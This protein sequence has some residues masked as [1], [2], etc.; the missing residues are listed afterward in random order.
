[1][2]KLLCFLQENIEIALSALGILGT[3]LGTWLGWILNTNTQKLLTKPFVTVGVGISTYGHHEI[4]ENLY[5]KEQTQIGARNIQ[6]I[7]ESNA[8]LIT[9][10]K[11][12]FGYKFNAKKSPFALLRVEYSTSAFD[13]KDY[14]LAHLEN[15]SNNEKPSYKVEPYGPFRSKKAR[16]KKQ[17]EIKKQIS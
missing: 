15:L 10:N 12:V 11:N 4:L 14:W 2:N 6:V 1:M 17:S 16:R 8:I 9:K 5:I 7:E 13:Y 3:L